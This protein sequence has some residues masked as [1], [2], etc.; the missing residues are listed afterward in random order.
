[1]SKASKYEYHPQGKLNRS[2]VQP[3]SESKS[4]RSFLAVS[5]VVNQRRQT[6]RSDTRAL[7][8]RATEGELLSLTSS[9]KASRE[10]ADEEESESLV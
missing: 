2:A 4:M 5:L 3:V 1:M 10:D 6:Q 7:T 9:H 8:R